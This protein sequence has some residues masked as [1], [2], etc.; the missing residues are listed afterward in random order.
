MRKVLWLPPFIIAPLLGGCSIGD[1]IEVDCSVGG[2]VGGTISWRCS[3]GTANAFPGGKSGPELTQIYD[4]Y[5]AMVS[6]NG[7]SVGVPTSGFFSM[8]AYD[9]SGSVVGTFSDSWDLVA[10]AAVANDPGDVDAW[11]YGLPVGVH[12]IKADLLPFTVIHT[13]G[14]NTFTASARQ[15]GVTYGMASTTFES[16]SC[17]GGSLGSAFACLD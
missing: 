14:S 15:S 2:E 17:N 9:A 6:F 3:V 11:L 5:S 10:N 12:E 4:P 16:R 8:S 7:S 13:P 1:K